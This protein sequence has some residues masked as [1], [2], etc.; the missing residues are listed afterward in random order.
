MKCKYS[1]TCAKYLFPSILAWAQV[2]LHRVF[3][4]LVAS[5]LSAVG[6]CPVKNMFS[7]MGSL[8]AKDPVAGTVFVHHHK[9]PYKNRT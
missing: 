7:I 5:E 3:K 9:V 1:R 4:L 6:V 2:C 8:W